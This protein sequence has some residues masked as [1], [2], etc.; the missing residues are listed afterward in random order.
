MSLGLPLHSL[1][2]RTPAVLLFN[3]SRDLPLSR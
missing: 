1:G 3:A 2:S